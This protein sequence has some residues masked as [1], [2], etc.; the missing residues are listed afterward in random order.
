MSYPSYK[1]SGSYK[2]FNTNTTATSYMYHAQV[3]QKHA[4]T[5]I[6]EKLLLSV[7]RARRLLRDLTNRAQR[8]Q[9]Q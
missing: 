4:H 2:Q 3:L 9:T 6:N 1:K 8:K 5:V 7:V